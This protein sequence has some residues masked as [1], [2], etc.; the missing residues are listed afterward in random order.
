MSPGNLCCCHF[1]RLVFDHRLIILPLV[2]LI[3]K[4]M[5]SRHSLFCHL[6]LALLLSLGA[7]GYCL[8]IGELSCRLDR[9]ALSPILIDGVIKGIVVAHHCFGRLFARCQFIESLFIL[10]II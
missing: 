7:D 9:D 1:I 3:L 2:N 5:A 10:Q 4:I 8:F 6:G